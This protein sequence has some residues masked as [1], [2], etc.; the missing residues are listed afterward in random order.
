MKLFLVLTCA[1]LGLS[2]ITTQAAESKSQPHEHSE[3]NKHDTEHAHDDDEHRDE[4]AHND[5]EH[6]DEHAH[7]D[8]EHHDEHAH[9]DDEHNDEHAHDEHEHGDELTTVITDHMT[10]QV[11]IQ[12]EH[13]S[14]M[15]LY[16]SIIVYGSLTT[17]PEQLSHVRARYPGIIKSVKP[18]LGDKVNRGDLLAEVESNESLNTYQVRSPI[19]GTIIT[20]HANIGEFTQEQVLF[21]IANFDTL[22][23]EFRVYPS[24]QSL[25]QVG[26]TAHI[27][28]SGLNLSGP[29]QHIIPALDKPYQ[30]A[31]VVFDNRQKK[32]SP[33][34]LV[35][36]RI[37]VDE[38]VAKL[39]VVNDAVQ[40]MNGQSGVFVKQGEAYAFTPLVL[41][42]RDDQ[43]VEVLSG[44][45]LGQEYVSKNSYLI[46]A[47]IE[48]SE[49]EHQH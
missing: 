19:A 44:L 2:Q 10:A 37:V 41:G 42:R 45:S 5:D 26:K 31:R 11:G 25:V 32:L 23:A 46:K 7:N 49:A 15:K 12:T 36:G 28:A 13:A 34:L 4:H 1:L 30:L 3:S 8:D 38:F 47:D 27:V 40:T 35:E 48:K 20:R 17:G 21:S 33:G 43:H 16:Q 14:S 6:H 29:I 39:A 22:W 9:N 18:T 24:Q